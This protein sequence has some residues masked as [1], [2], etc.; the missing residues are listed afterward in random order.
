VTLPAE[1][2]AELHEHDPP[3]EEVW[4]VVEGEVSL[5]VDGERERRSIPR[6]RAQLLP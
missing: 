2:A 5:V 6:R 3:Q 1:G 4:N